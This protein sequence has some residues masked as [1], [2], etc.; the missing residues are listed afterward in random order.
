MS[1]F[2]AFVICLLPILTLGTPVPKKHPSPPPHSNST[3]PW[4]ESDAAQS[5]G[6]STPAIIGIVLGGLLGVMLFGW[7]IYRLILRGGCCF[8]C[9]SEDAEEIEM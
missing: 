9:T 1:I 8:C 7:L 5:P 2:S 6:L 4:D 3:I